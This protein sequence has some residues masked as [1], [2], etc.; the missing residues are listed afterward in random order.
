LKF[1]GTLPP[2]LAPFAGLDLTINGFEVELFESAD[3]LYAKA[4]DS[5]TQPYCF[6]IN[7]KKF[8]PADHEYDIEVLFDKAALPDTNLDAY[9]PLVKIP[10]FNGY[11]QWFSSG[12]AALFPYITEFI[13]RQETD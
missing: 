4:T 8:Q 13:A 10:D 6:G 5:D 11:G 3:D 1:E 7:F 9:D 2:A 12:A